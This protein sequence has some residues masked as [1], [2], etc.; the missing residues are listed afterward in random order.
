MNRTKLNK[1]AAHEM[2]EKKQELKRDLEKK[3]EKKE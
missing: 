1:R 2:T 3:I